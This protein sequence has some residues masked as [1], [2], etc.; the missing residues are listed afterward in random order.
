MKPR[1]PDK[2]IV[3]VDEEG[4]RGYFLFEKRG[5]YQPQRLS[6]PVGWY[7]VVGDEKEYRSA[8]EMRLMYVAA[9]R[10]RNIVIVSTYPFISGERRAW[11]VLDDALGEIPELQISA[12]E[13]FKEREKLVVKKSE[14]KKARTG[15]EESVE[16]VNRPSYRVET[17]TSLAKESV[18]V[19]ERHRSGLGM[20]WGRV[21]HSVLDAIGKDKDV[22]RDWLIENALT[23]EEID[24]R[25]KTALTKLVASICESSFWKRAMQA[26]KRFFEVPFSIETKEKELEGT[27]D[28]PVILSGAI[29]LVFLEDGGWVIA[30]YK[31]DEIRNNLQDYVDYY[32]PQVKLYSKYWAEITGEN[33]KEAGLYFTAV[34]KWIAI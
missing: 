9:T 4:P 27:G 1:E 24:L 20:S 30:D 26:E 22:D 33:V 34:N 8:E 16:S 17:V 11:A 29:D 25:E 21:V 18:D 31:T 28:L 15:L 3:R 19:P 6:Q 14:L 23:A 12:G 7:G 10:A 32:A 2:H 13:M 5:W